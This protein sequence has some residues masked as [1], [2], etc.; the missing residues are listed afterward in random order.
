MEEL[1]VELV[2]YDGSGCQSPFYT[3]SPD[4]IEVEEGCLWEG[5]SWRLSFNHIVQEGGIMQPCPHCVDRH[6]HR[7]TRSDHSTWDDVV[8]IAPRVVIAYN[9]GGCNTTGVCLDCILTHV[10]AL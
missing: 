6:I 5:G 1:R 7:H 3:N 9:E 4:D 8:W 2:E 10:K